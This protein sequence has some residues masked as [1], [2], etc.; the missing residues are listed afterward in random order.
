MATIQTD[1]FGKV[2]NF[3]ELE[4][5]VVFTAIGTPVSVMLKS[6]AK[7]LLLDELY[8]P[9]FDGSIEVDIKDII[10]SEMY[11]LLPEE[12]IDIQQTEIYKEFTLRINDGEIE[13]TFTVCGFSEEC[14]GRLTDI[15]ILRV[16]SDYKIPLS[17]V[18]SWE[19]D[20]IRYKLPDGRYIED[21]GLKTTNSIGITSRMLD[22]AS[23]PVANEN[24]F[25]IELDCGENILSTAAFHITSGHFEQYL[26]ANRYGG[27]DNIPMSGVRE[28]Q[29]D[30][31]FETGIYNNVSEQIS[32][33]SETIYIQNSGFLSSKVIELASELLCS[34]QIY[35][36]DQNGEFRRI[37]L[38]DSSLSIKSGDSLHSFSF[39]YKY[40][41]DSRPASLR[42]RSI[43]GKTTSKPEKTLVYPITESPMTITHDRNRFPSVTVID[44]DRQVV[45]TSIEYPDS[46]NV[47]IS[48]TGE[49]Q[50]Y[51]YIN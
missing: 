21:N 18:N 37:I 46:N 51:V 17:L 4:P 26:F 24:C 43:A 27:F 50:G 45:I 36:L 14:T 28:F 23:S 44:Q 38:L 11:L 22:L 41:D 5:I 8:Y 31:S 49:L 9:G 6:D 40:A 20:G 32:A 25:V 13:G 16:P 48:W 35:H 10:A 12:G 42:Y 2:V 3:F 7:G 15:D 34:P 1:I 47:I 39:K 30:L 29:P 33:D 19:R